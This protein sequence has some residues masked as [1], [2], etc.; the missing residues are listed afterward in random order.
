M[1]HQTYVK[2]GEHYDSILLDMNKVDQNDCTS[3]KTLQT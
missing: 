1:K 2:T 3:T